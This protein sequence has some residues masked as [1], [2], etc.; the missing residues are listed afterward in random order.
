[1]A[2]YNSA[3]G[4]PVDT[5]Q[6]AYQY[7][8][9]EQFEQA[10][11][12]CQQLGKSY[13]RHPDVQHLQA[14][15]F[16][17]QGQFRQGMQA[18]QR[19][20]KQQPDNP[21][22]ALTLARI[23]YGLGRREAAEQNVVRVLNAHQKLVAAH[24]QLAGWLVQQQR[25]PEAESHYRQALDQQPD[26]ARL[27][28]NLAT[29]LHEQKHYQQAI[30]CY[31]RALAIQPDY[32]TAM[33][34]LANSQKSIEAYTDAAETFRQALKLNPEF[35]EPHIQLGEM[36][37]YQGRI[38]EAASEYR[39][40]IGLRP[41]F[42]EAYRLLSAV[43]K[44][45][46]QTDIDAMEALAAGPIGDNENMHLQFALAKVYEDRGDTDKAFQAMSRANGLYRAR[47]D[48]DVQKDV[49]FMQRLMTVFDADFFTG[50]ACEPVSDA[51]PLFIIGM[52]RSGTTLAESILS[53][54]PRVFG[55]GEI[56]VLAELVAASGKSFPTGVVG[57][58]QQ[59]VATMAA[60]YMAHMARLNKTGKKLVVN[61]MPNN[62]LYLGLIY[63]LFPRARVIHCRRDPVDTCLSCFKHYFI[64]PQP[65]AYDLMDLCHYYSAYQRL[66]AHWQ[67]VLPGY[68]HELRYENLVQDP[69]QQIRQLLAYCGLEWDARCLEFHRHKR[70]VRTASSA[71][72]RQPIYQSSAHAWEKYRQ[73]LQPLIQCLQGEST[74]L[75]SG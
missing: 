28:N 13:A 27:Y 1:M 29:V 65:F 44:D 36:L 56:G 66:M 61:K 51:A 72:V 38:E 4:Q 7:L 8:A 69:E 68:I 45:H 59:A 50:H 43:Q 49:D 30:D 58:P 64:G 18:I 2:D 74:G 25:Y 23:Q 16:E 10:E 5:I 53:S 22:Y 40:A 33:V 46:Q 42:T 57:M 39:E 3:K 24:T 54:H 21:A 48:Y 67:A 19:A 9:A 17:Q 32:L 41:N 47:L 6:Q 70:Q 14:L 20:V 60:D 52:P 35:A 55:A 12:L 71:Q 34:N 31:Q 75:S 73:H 15:L 26:D 11:Q 37:R 63:L 62:F